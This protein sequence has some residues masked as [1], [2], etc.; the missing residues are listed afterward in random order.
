[1]VKYLCISNFF[2]YSSYDCKQ[3]TQ[4]SFKIM[5]A[6]TNALQH[7]TKNHIQVV[8]VCSH[9][10][11]KWDDETIR[12]SRLLPSSS[13]GGQCLLKV[14]NLNCW[15]QRLS[16]KTPLCISNIGVFFHSLMQ[17]SFS[18]AQRFGASHTLWEAVLSCGS[19]QSCY[20]TPCMQSMF[21]SL[22]DDLH[23]FDFFLVHQ[24]NSTS[25][26]IIR[27]NDF[28]FLNFYFF[29]MN[30]QNQNNKWSKIQYKL[31]KI[32]TLNIFF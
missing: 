23:H 4:N 2:F 19:S 30:F 16:S 9:H 12:C 11:T 21:A 10:T 7:D 24:S 17:V 25:G 15:F 14:F 1:M 6:I 13:I 27:D 29:A 26:N 18:S 8:N 32:N 5:A 28:I 3:H 31:L 20:Y 22:A